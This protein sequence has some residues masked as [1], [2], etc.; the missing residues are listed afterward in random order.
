[1]LRKEHTNYN[2]ISILIFVFLNFA[3]TQNSYSGIYKSETV[4][5]YSE[6]KIARQWKTI[7]RGHMEGKC[8]VF[9]VKKTIHILQVRICGTFS[10][11]E[12]K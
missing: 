1:M 4:I 12:N 6:G 7:D 11:E 2:K 9:N 8:Y 3:L 5:L 10:V